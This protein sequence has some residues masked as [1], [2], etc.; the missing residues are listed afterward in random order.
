MSNLKENETLVK[1]NSMDSAFVYLCSNSLLQAE[2]KGTT[3]FIKTKQNNEENLFM[4]IFC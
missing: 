3:I 2:R 1:N 4:L